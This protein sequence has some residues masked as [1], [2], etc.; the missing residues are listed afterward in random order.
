MNASGVASLKIRLSQD[1][2]QIVF[3]DPMIDS[4][5]D[6]L[7]RS[8]L[9]LKAAAEILRQLGPASNAVGKEPELEDMISE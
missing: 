6:V 4:L 7:Q 5:I 1:P 9:K 2:A 3:T 8:K